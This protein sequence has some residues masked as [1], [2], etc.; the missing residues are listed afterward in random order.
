MYDRKPHPFNVHDLGR[1]AR[2][3]PDDM[4]FSQE[5]EL[6]EIILVLIAKLYQAVAKTLGFFNAYAQLFSWAVKILTNTWALITSLSRVPDNAKP[7]A[8]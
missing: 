7:P 4:E 1:I 5:A 2:K 6:L 8:I 3:L